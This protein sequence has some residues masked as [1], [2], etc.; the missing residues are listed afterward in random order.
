MDVH[1]ARQPIGLYNSLGISQANPQADW[2]VGLDGS[3]VVDDVF[4]VENLEAFAKA[5]SVKFNAKFNPSTKVNVS[6][7]V[8]SIDEAYSDPACAELVRRI[9]KTDF[10]LFDYCEKTIPRLEM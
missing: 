5:M 10:D 9:Y 8:L 1:L 7:K 4:K 2:V 3:F 6:N